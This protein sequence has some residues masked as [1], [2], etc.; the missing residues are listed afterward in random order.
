METNE[1]ENK[2]IEKTSQPKNQLFG[3]MKKIDKYQLDQ[4][5]EEKKKQ[6]QIFKI[7]NERGGIT[8]GSTEI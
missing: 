5:D 3:K 4:I 2:T 8:N 7:M 1:T 6:S